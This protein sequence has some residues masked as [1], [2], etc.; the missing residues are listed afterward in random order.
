MKKFLF[1]LLLLG[2]TIAFGQSFTDIKDK[3]SRSLYEDNWFNFMLRQT[4]VNG[5]DYSLGGA[6]F[7]LSI[8]NANADKGNVHFQYENVWLGDLVWVLANWKKQDKVKMANGSGLLGWFQMHYNVKASDKFILA[9]GL[10]VG[11]R[12][13]GH[14]VAI[15]TQPG[16]L[17][18]DP[19]GYFFFAGPSVKS[20]YLIN[21]DFWVDGIATFDIPFARVKE[22]GTFNADYQTEKGYPDP[23]FGNITATLYHKSK[24]FFSIRIDH[25]F[26][27]GGNNGGGTRT[28]F[29]LGYQF[30]H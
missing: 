27:R 3:K 19:F 28:D 17:S 13:Y 18:N 1:A 30:L 15:E 16:I 2:G 24:L 9:P 11:D 10:S 21:K 20:S 4:Q 22:G 5:R 29:S 12:I 23:W 6:T 25:A 7:N 14:E 8:R 26:D